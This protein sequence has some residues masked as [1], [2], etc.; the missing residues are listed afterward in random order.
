MWAALE[1]LS[2]HVKRYSTVL[3]QIWYICVF[4]FRLIVVSTIGGAVYGDEQSQFKCSTLSP[5]C[6][7]MCFNSFSK[8]SHMR[9][10]AFQ[11][12]GVL[13]PTVF[14]HFYANRVTGKIE[15]LKQQSKTLDPKARRNSERKLK[16]VKMKTVYNG[17]DIKQLPLTKKIHLAYYLSVL[18]RMC[19]EGFFIYLAHLLFRFNSPA[20]TIKGDSIFNFILFE[21]PGMYLCSQEDHA[22]YASCKQHFLNGQGYVPCWSSRP[23]EKTIFI[24]YMNI[25]SA[26]CFVLSLIELI[27][28][29]FKGL[30]GTNCRKCKRTLYTQAKK[31]NVNESPQSPSSSLPF[32]SEFNVTEETE[33][34]RGMRE[35]HRDRG[36]GRWV[37]NGNSLGFANSGW[38]IGSSHKISTPER[39]PR[40]RRTQY[41]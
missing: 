40:A 2:E 18:L 30:V 31:Y 20:K 36:D 33:L 26:V 10:W 1:K 14:F 25:F 17:I 23:W 38:F 34:S 37:P 19:V 22:V 41:V 32:Q 15:K 29:T 5:G 35:D 9:F 11:L 21:V 27:Y 12:L 3:G 8:I 6:E 39:R 16:D 24:R 13:A 4:I 7:N 28:L